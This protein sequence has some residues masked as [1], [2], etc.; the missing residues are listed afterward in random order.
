LYLDYLDTGIPGV[1]F[2][3]EVSQE[4]ATDKL[5]LHFKDT[6]EGFNSYIERNESPLDREVLI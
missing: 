1:R 5:E 3:R 4:R 6:I 2:V